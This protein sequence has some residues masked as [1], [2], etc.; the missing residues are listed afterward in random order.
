[1]KKVLIIGGGMAGCCAAHQFSLMQ[2]KFEVTIIEA[3]NIL[4]AGVR[5]NWWG[6]HPYTYGPR[7]FLTPHQHVFD[8]FNK[9]VP[10]RL[11]ADHQALTYVAPS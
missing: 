9:Y 10:L 6:G 7:H 2:K 1:M 11:C 8:Y 3:S 5:T 4:G